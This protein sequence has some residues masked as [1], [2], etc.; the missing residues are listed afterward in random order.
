MHCK[1][2]GEISLFKINHN[3]YKN[4]FFSSTTIEWN[5]LDHGFRNSEICTLFRSNIL[6]FIR[7]SPNSLYSCQNIIGIK[8]ITICLGLSHLREH[9]FKY[10]FQDTLN[11]LCNCGMN[12]EPS[13]H[14]LLQCSPYINERCTL[15]SNLNRINQQIFQTFL[16]FLTNTLLFRTLSYSDKTKTHILNASI[17]YIRLI[18]RLDEPF[19]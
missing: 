12:V 11:P 15:M 17:D 19:F 7:P 14:I 4:L 3:F 1:K 9:K 5:D 18:K 8:L 6:K 2:T 13:T 10:S 16:Q